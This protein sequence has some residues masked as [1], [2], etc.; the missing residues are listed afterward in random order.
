MGGG[1]L[2]TWHCKED[3]HR[4][5]QAMISPAAGVL[6]AP[7][8]A[9]PDLAPAQG[10]ALGKLRNR[11][12]RV[13]VFLSVSVGTALPAPSVWVWAWAFLTTAARPFPAAGPCPAVPGCHCAGQMR[14]H[15]GQFG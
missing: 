4:D 3:R 13:P 14:D 2:R 5:R 8:G 11:P 6:G 1:D 7:E 15:R 10:P 12:E 9:D